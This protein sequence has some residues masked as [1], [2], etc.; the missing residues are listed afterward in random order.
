[1][2]NRRRFLAA[3]AG[4]AVTGLAAASA[5]AANGQAAA[6][7]FSVEAAEFGVRPSA[8]ED[9]SAAFAKMLG[10]ASDRDLAVFLP[11]GRY[12]V[13]DILLPRAVRLTGIAGATR[14]VNGGGRRF[15]AANEAEHIQLADLSFDGGAHFLAGEAPG[16][17]SLAN[18]GRLAIDGC[19]FAASSGHG[20]S[21]Q[22]C[23]GRVERSRVSGAADA[24]LYLNDSAGLTIT[25]NEV[26]DCGNGGILVHR[27]QPGA[28]ATIVSANRIAGI[29]AR[30]GGTGQN[31]NG[32]NAFRADEVIVSGNHISDCAFSAIRGNSAGNFQVA[33]N[34]CLRSGE[35]AIY[36]E[37][38]FQGAVV[39]ANI[40]D[41][42]ANG[43]SI[44]N[45]DH[46]GRMATVSGNIVRN[47]SRAGPYTPDPPGFGTGIGVEADVALTGNLVENAPLHGIGIG[48]GPFM[49]NVVATGNIVRKA[50]TGI[51]V[52]VVE[53]AGAAV[54]TDNLFEAVEKGAVV[55]YRWA[56]AA[57]GDLT[58]EG[59]ELPPRLIVA[60]NSVT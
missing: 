9:Q 22:K 53:G 26:A 31:G 39:S 59:A 57:T 28:D 49:R 38:A 37:F 44:A 17:L 10:A 42:A 43:I 27:S 60:R 24:G 8:G 32:I 13:S 51:A 14:L 11:P 41:G 46:G 21:L 29:R 19:E 34:T 5:R 2:P 55:G 20:L 48:W 35:T 6:I 36:S 50:G 18:V 52:T 12:I 7:R 56:E 25:G 4:F 47:L 54:I 30:D 15:L 16:L 33:G 58:A 1:M 3:T 40:V 23:A 45:L